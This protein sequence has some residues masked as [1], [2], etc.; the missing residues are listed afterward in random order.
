MADLILVVPPVAYR[1]VSAS[2]ISVFRRSGRRL[3]ALL[4]GGE[5]RA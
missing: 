4:Q 3:I 1:I 2:R 5:G